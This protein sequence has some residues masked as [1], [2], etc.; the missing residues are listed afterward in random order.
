MPAKIFVSYSHEDEAMRA[1]L[2]VHLK[3]LIREG[4]IDAWH[5][6][7]LLAG[8]NIDEGI[9]E[10]LESADIILFL[11]SPDFLASNY[12]IEREFKRALER[13]QAG[14]ARAVA[15]ILEPCDWMHP[16]LSQFLALP[17]D[18]IPISKWPIHNEAFLY[19]VKQIRLIL[20]TL[21]VSKGPASSSPAPVAR[22]GIP[23]QPTHRSSNLAIHKQFR[24]DERGR[25]LNDSFVFIQNYFEQSLREL[26]A[27]NNE[28]T[29]EFRPLDADRFT[30]KIYRSG[31]EESACSIIR[32]EGGLAGRWGITYQSGIA[33]SRNTMEGSLSVADDGQALGFD[34][35]GLN[36]LGMRMKVQDQANLLSQEGAAESLWARL[37]EPLQRPR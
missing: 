34:K 14:L 1:R 16:P 10:A 19:V 15:I 35:D 25:F 7:R 12:C 22:V 23:F 2:E 5:D 31:E 29:T 27:R 3:P 21:P 37:I 24:D 4:L 30:A 20:E 28:I 26:Q 9:S 32:S 13:Q 17:E 33:A 36:M 11:V 18:G 8:D 6:R